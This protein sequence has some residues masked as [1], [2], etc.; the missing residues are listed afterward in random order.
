MNSQYQGAPYEDLVNDEGKPIMPWHAEGQDLDIEE[1]REA[2]VG[3]RY[4][5][6]EESFSQF[7]EEE[8]FRFT[9]CWPAFFL[10]GFWFLY[11]KIY[12]MGILLVLA[13]VL[14]QFIFGI[15][16][17][18]GSMLM[19]LA[20]HLFCAMTGN[21]YYWQLVEEKTQEALDL[22]AG[23]PRQMRGWM[24]VQG[25]T[26]MRPIVVAAL[27]IALRIFLYFMTILGQVIGTGMRGGM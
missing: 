27:L 24:A 13:T 9:V 6:F 16:G 2:W 25:G 4:E 18:L 3:D 23:E 1:A 10:G 15:F 20:A 8:S 14:L 12:R 11:R 5:K 7:D 22:F 21:W 19:I 26:D 17:P